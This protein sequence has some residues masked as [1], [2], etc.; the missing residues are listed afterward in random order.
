[1]SFIAFLKYIQQLQGAVKYV[2]GVACW[3]FLRGVHGNH[4]ILTNYFCIAWCRVS[5]LDCTKK[6]LSDG[7]VS[8]TSEQDAGKDRDE[9]EDEQEKKVW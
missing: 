3:F 8:M 4:Q 9:E 5:F 7:G 2:E 6:I 1:M